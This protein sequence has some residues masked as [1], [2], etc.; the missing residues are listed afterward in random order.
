MLHSVSMR[1][2]V[3]FD[4]FQ[5][6]HS[7]RSAVRK[8]ENPHKVIFETLCSKYILFYTINNQQFLIH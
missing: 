2:S 3:S 1:V 6:S 4:V 8:F 7:T 5:K